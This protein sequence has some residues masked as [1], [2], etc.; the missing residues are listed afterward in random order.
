MGLTPLM[1]LFRQTFRAMAAEHEIQL[2]APDIERARRAAEAAIA[3]V[4][5]IEAKYSRYRDDSVTSRINHAAGSEEVAI[6]A[7]QRRSCAMR[8]SATD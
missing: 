6:D 7:E 8:T 1:K 5:R 2:A 3:D 4:M